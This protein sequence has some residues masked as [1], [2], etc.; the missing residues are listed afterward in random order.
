MRQL[1][2]VLLIALFGV[3]PLRAQQ[4]LHTGVKL[5]A[6]SGTVEVHRANGWVP[7]SVDDEVGP[8]ERVRTADGSTA[9]LE[10]GPKKVI[11]LREHTEIQLRDSGEMPSIHHGSMKVVSAANIE[12]TPKQTMPETAMETIPETMEGPID[13]LPLP[14]LPALLAPSLPPNVLYGD[15][16]FPPT[17]YVYPFSLGDDRRGGRGRQPRDSGAIVPPVVNNPTSPGYQPNQIVPPMSDPIHIP[18]K[19]R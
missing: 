6:R 17:Y 12:A 19:Q 5:V 9:A 15:Y 4:D 3:A 18:I 8:T 10:L 1:A 13:I 14:P 16:I 11:A 2:Y 7:L